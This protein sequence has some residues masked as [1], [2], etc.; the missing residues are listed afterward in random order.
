M[1]QE[2][3]HVLCPQCGTF[4]EADPELSRWQ[5]E[6]TLRLSA[7][8]A[9]RVTRQ[10]TSGYIRIG[11]PQGDSAPRIVTA[12]IDSGELELLPS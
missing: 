11:I 1:G 12:R 2:P 8:V 4:G 3:T 6:A 10:V 5:C 9:Y 7:S